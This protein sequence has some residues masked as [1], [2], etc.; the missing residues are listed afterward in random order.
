[1]L[2]Q[3]RKLHADGGRIGRELLIWRLD[4][5]GC[6]GRRGGWLA[7]CERGVTSSGRA[8]VVARPL[9]LGGSA[10]Y[11]GLD[12]LPGASC[13]L[14]PWQSPTSISG[15]PRTFLSRSMVATAAVVA[16]ERAGSALL[17]QGDLAGESV[18]LRIVGAVNEL[19][20]REPRPG[21]TRELRCLLALGIVGIALARL[22]TAQGVPWGWG[23][24]GHDIVAEIAEHYLEP[25]TAR[26]SWACSRWGTTL[27]RRHRQLG[28]SMHYHGGRKPPHGITST[29]RSIHRSRRQR[30][31][32]PRATARAAPAS[33][34]RLMNSPRLLE[35]RHR[36][37]VERLEALKFLTHLIG[38]IHQ[39]LHCANNNDHGGNDIRLQ[40]GSR[41]PIS[42]RIWDTDL[43]ALIVQDDT[44]STAT[45]LMK[46]ITD[47]R[48]G[49]W[50][51]SS[52]DRLGQ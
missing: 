15:G 11:S 16:A 31:T 6:C 28:R 21:G 43:V 24:E 26:G 13:D 5:V 49:Y 12:L 40:F 25:E 8:G 20:R 38:D 41:E 10:T 46:D 51:E 2:R 4:R 45:R 29:F 18:W 17:A 44:R 39:P 7:E 1:M 35:D 23:S 27:P 14:W 48:L 34:R 3:Y 9:T 32:M 37:P 42:H 50:Q 22:L 33:S 52:A 30:G 19:Q 36:S 47:V